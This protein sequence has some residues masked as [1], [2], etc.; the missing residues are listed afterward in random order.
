MKS[1]RPL[2]LAIVVVALGP[3]VYATGCGSDARATDACRRIES[4]RCERAPSCPQQYPAFTSLYGDVASCQRFYDTQ[5]GRGVQE[6]AKE[7]SKSELD[8]C[9]KVIR[10]NCEAVADPAKFCPFL[11]ANEKPVDTDTGTPAVETGTDAADG[12]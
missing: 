9:I 11:I 2:V 1:A 5:C 8:N 6:A 10:E 7:P 3:A 4:T 12:G